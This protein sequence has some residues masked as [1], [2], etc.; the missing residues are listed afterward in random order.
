MTA[1]R[2]EYI[3]KFDVEEE[4]TYLVDEVRYINS[5]G[6]YETKVREEIG[7][8]LMQ[9]PR[10]DTTELLRNMSPKF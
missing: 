3:L 6:W 5:Q 8:K 2:G 7:N 10:A 1:E 9:D 4:K